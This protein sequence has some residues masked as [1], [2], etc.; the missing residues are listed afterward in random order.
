MIIKNNKKKVNTQT[1]DK[2]IK[3]ELR[4]FYLFLCAIH[5]RQF[6]EIRQ[7]DTGINLI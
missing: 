2:K 1:P 6:I 4:L 7:K 3:T 5:Y